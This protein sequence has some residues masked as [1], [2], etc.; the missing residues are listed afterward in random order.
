MPDNISIREQ[1]ILLNSISCLIRSEEKMRIK[2]LNRINNL[3]N[4]FYKAGSG[5][6]ALRKIVLHGGTTSACVLDCI[7]HS[8][9]IL[10]ITGNK[11][12][13]EKIARFKSIGAKLSA[14]ENCT[15]SELPDTQKD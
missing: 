5:Q 13:K 3:L 4:Q 15:A 6:E 9:A 7:T 1:H 10:S 14:L 11:D 2:D 12:D 8:I